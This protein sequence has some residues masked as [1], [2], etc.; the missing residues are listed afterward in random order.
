MA[1]Y[2]ANDC[3]FIISND[4]K[5][6]D[7]DEIINKLVLTNRKEITQPEISEVCG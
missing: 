3:C 4:A 7:L 1:K 6:I 2:K 5:M